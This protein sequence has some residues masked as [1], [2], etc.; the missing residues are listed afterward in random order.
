MENVFKKT[1]MKNE[2]PSMSADQQPTSIYRPEQGTKGNLLP[3]AGRWQNHQAIERLG[4][5]I[6]LIQKLSLSEIYSH[7]LYTQEGFNYFTFYFY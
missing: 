5:M 7:Q 3:P 1:V 4:N 6:Q 2:Q